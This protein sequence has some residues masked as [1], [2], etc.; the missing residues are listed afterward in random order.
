MVIYSRFFITD[1]Y[2][3]PVEDVVVD[4]DFEVDDSAGGASHTQKR[5]K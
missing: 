5:R 3:S 2:F 4:D 1:F